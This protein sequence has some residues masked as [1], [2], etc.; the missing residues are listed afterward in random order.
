MGAAAAWQLA[1][2]GHDVT[3]FEQFDRLHDRGSSHG[4]ARVFRLG[5]PDADWVRFATEALALWRDLQEESG[6]ELLAHVGAID[7]GEPQHVGAIADALGAAGITHER[8]TP[9]EAGV[10]WV[11]MRFDRGVVFHPDGGRA[12][13]EATVAALL[14]TAERRGAEVRVHTPVEYLE[15]GD[16]HVVVHAATGAHRADRVVVTAGAWAGSL[17]HG[18]VDLPALTVTQEQPAHFTPTSDARWPAFL[19]YAPGPSKVNDLDDPVRS[20]GVPTPEGMVKIGEHHTGQETDPDTRSWVA[21]PAR[22]ERLKAYVAEWFP[23]LDVASAAPE[24]CLYTTTRT[25]DFVLDRVGPIVV[26]AGFS[27]HGFKFV[28]RVG[29]VLADLVEG[30]PTPQSR[31]RLARL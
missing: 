1:R 20:Y 29:A 9:D 21:D 3:V 14:D 15:I 8:L 7:H 30:R 18:V 17:L 10:R 22:H 28:P 19:H 26:G 31:F 25:T 24:T 16:D 2:R 13:A 5:Y 27:G 4:T 23:G 6:R 12:N 11:G